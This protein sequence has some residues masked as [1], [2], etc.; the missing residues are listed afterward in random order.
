[1]TNKAL[2]P[3]NK[4]Y[5]DLESKVGTQSNV[6]NEEELFGAHKTSPQIPTL[7]PIENKIIN[8]TNICI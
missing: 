8:T 1:M 2:S 4:N 7:L 3:I 6:A 5:N